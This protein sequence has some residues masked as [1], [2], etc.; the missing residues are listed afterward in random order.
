MKT[1]RIFLV[2]LLLI[3]TASYAKLVDAVALTVDGRPITLSEIAKVQR[4]AHVDRRTAIDLLIRDRLQKEA[5]KDIVVTDKELDR[6]IARIAEHYRMD[7]STLRK[8][9]EAEGTSWK[10]YRRTLR[11]SL[12]QRIFFRNKIVPSIPE[13]S[14]SVLRRFYRAH[15]ENFTIPKVVK[16]ERYRFKTRQAAQRFLKGIAKPT[17]KPKRMR[18]STA[19]LDN[20][21][22]QLLAHLPN[23]AYSDPIDTKNGTVVYKVLGKSG[24]RT[25]SF[26]E[27]KALAAMQWR[28]QH[29]EEAVK[30]YFDKM[31]ADADIRY[32][33]N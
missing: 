5:M 8:R 29:R 33:R 16:V 22:A 6:E 24:K 9:L 1:Y 17:H 27:A 10:A 31:K 11:T 18:L 25:L 15:R 13:P 30:H 23:G 12:K 7:V 28:M 3:G 20:E 4:I 2:A 19:T 32:L 26:E 14:E 21:T